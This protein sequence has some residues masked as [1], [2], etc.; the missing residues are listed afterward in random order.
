MILP[1][2]KTQEELVG[3]IV[4]MVSIHTDTTK[5]QEEKDFLL[6]KD[7]SEYLPLFSF[8]RIVE[9]EEMTEAKITEDI[10]FMFE[11]NNMK[12]NKAKGFK[13]F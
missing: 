13:I 12:C 7:F 4:R 8:L 10:E 5:G 9:N 2:G 3:T 1:K 11:I 6:Q